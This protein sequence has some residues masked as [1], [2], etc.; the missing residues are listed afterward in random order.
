MKTTLKRLLNR[1]LPEK[2]STY[3]DLK[4]I[5]DALQDIQSKDMFTALLKYRLS[6]RISPLYDM[7][8]EMDR[9][10]EKDDFVE[11]IKR[12]RNH[13]NK[14]RI[15]IYNLGGGA[16]SKQLTT[17]IL[18]ILSYY[19]VDIYK[20]VRPGQ[21]IGQLEHN[22]IIIM[23]PWNLRF[24][25]RDEIHKIKQMGKGKIIWTNSEWCE[26]YF[27][28]DIMIPGKNEVFVDAGCLNGDTSIAFVNWC[29]GN[30]EWIYAFEPD[31]NS[32][33]N[34][35]NTFKKN[36]LKNI[37]LI[38]AGCWDKIE[39]LSFLPDTL[40]GSRIVEDSD[41]T[42]DT[43]SI[44]EALGGKRVTFLK[45]DIEGA[46]LKALIGAR[47]TIKKYK[48][49]LAICIYHKPED[50][51]DIALYILSL[52]PEYKLYIRHATTYRFGTVLMAVCDNKPAPSEAA[53]H[54]N[55]WDD[56]RNLNYYNYVFEAA[57][58]FIPS[59]NSIIDIGS[60]GIPF[61]EELDWINN[62]YSLD[63]NRP[64]ESENVVGYK[65][66]FLKFVPKMHYDAALCMQTLEHID[67][68]KEFAKKIFEI[69]DH[70]ILTVPYKWPAGSCKWHVHDMIGL[71]TM[72]EWTGMDPDYYL[73]VP[74]VSWEWGPGAPLCR[75]I[76]YYRFTEG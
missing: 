72:K 10:I 8:L 36:G 71:D 47:E 19:G 48:P 9:K 2:G 55:Y 27:A 43:I 5:Y 13:A 57:K 15:I 37:S 62:R 33:I 52:V 44:D 49:R 38:N 73:V 25:S 23:T 50:I 65:E 22:D 32:I 46:E 26:E 45:F 60:N 30:Y 1:T 70:I 21:D 67:D 68:P 18:S 66:D 31:A 6:G 51:T 41:F 34:C 3:A 17:E 24:S 64:Y 11:L 16:Y 28:P 75:L 29:K 42:I 74:E 39:K 35:K 4:Q 40:G 53:M 58:K 69:A 54:N 14:D 63:I 59:A 56:R 7:L 76:C 20:H 61:I 12:N